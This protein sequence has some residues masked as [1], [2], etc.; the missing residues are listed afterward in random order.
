[1]VALSVSISAMMSPGLIAWPSFTSHLASFP[2]SIVGESAGIKISV[3]IGVGLSLAFPCELQRR[4][5]V[6]SA[7]VLVI[8]ETVSPV[9]LVAA[10]STSTTQ[11]SSA[12]TGICST[13]FGTT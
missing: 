8:G 12:A 3:G 5:A 11:H 2:S 1:M 7:I 10:G 9:C 6:C 4:C 13:P